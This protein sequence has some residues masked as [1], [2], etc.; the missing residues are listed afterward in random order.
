MKQTEN[1][2]LKPPTKRQ[3][4]RMKARNKAFAKLTPAKQRVQIA[5]DVL[6]QL[7]M[8]ALVPA[9]RYFS[10]GDINDDIESPDLGWT[11]LAKGSKAVAK[12]CDLSFVAEKVPCTVC[13][14]GSLFV[15]AAKRADKFGYRDHI[16]RQAIVKYLDPYFTRDVLDQIEGYFEAHSGNSAWWSR[17]PKGRMQAIMNNIITHGGEFVPRKEWS[18]F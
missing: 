6:T 4:E 16:S 3:K 10:L 8:G 14:I 17:T 2:V 5:K 11:P 7:S 9:S 18:N 12:K 1:I 15:A 13:G